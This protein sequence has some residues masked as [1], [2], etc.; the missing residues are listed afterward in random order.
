MSPRDARFLDH[1]CRG[2]TLEEC[3]EMRKRID[4]MNECEEVEY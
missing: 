1:Y 3:F 2:R 4:K